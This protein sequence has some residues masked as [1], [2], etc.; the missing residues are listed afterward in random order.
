MT[1]NFNSRFAQRF[2]IFFN[3]LMCAVT[4]CTIMSEFVIKNGMQEN[5]YTSFSTIFLPHFIYILVLEIIY[6][7]IMQI[8]IR[9]DTKVSFHARML[10]LFLTLSLILSFVLKNTFIALYVFFTTLFQYLLTSTLFT[11]FILHDN[12]EKVVE[13]KKGLEL[14]STLAK[15]KYVAQEFV[16]NI[17][18][19]KT[20]LIIVSIILSALSMISNAAFSNKNII[21]FICTFIYILS[22]FGISQ[23]LSIYER[24][25]Y[26]AFLGFEKIF[27]MRT[28]IF[29][30]SMIFVFICL[31]IGLLL[32]SN[33]QL[34]KKEYFDWFFNLFKREKPLVHV[35]NQPLPPVSDNFADSVSPGK[36]LSTA[37]K[38]NLVLQLI[39]KI[40]QYSLLAGIIIGVLVFLFKPIFDK[41]LGIELKKHNFK[42]ILSEFFQK[43]LNMF[44]DFFGKKRE[45]VPYATVGTQSFKFQMSDMLG[46]TKKSKEKKAELDRLTKEFVKIISWGEQQQVLFK[47]N[48]APAEYTEILYSFSKINDLHKIGFLFEKALYSK[49]LLS[50]DEEKE[51][52]ECIQKVLETEIQA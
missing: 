48:H 19:I 16:Q 43:M 11:S 25:I 49:D 22:A 14:Q 40:I 41:S 10:P 27:D 45:F 20:I 51:Y 35:E 5:G 8:F 7:F 38:P 18:N 32:S 13:N 37:E 52:K 23:L 50:K 24:E 28:V 47:K 30:F 3:V 21:P 33:N 29:F 34:L 46:K 39:I 42:Q 36:L 31:L 1:I 26:Y 17:S 15:D 9:A 2:L 6:V 12:F 44:R 4:I